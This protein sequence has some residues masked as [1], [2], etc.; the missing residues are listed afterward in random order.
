MSFCTRE[1]ASRHRP[2]LVAPLVALPAF[3]A[4]ALGP[5]PPP[6]DMTSP[7]RMQ[8]IL[9]LSEKAAALRADIRAKIEALQHR[10]ERCDDRELRLLKLIC[11]A[12]A[13][14]THAGKADADFAEETLEEND[15]IRARIE[16]D[17]DKLRSQLSRAQPLSCGPG[18][19]TGA[20]TQETAA[21]T[22]D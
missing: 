6:R 2:R 7:E 14:R 3:L 8:E 20:D 16:R 1:K 13:E 19:D 18:I 22:R 15:R 9:A 12:D 21:L 4:Q 17:L 5:L 11:E 10:L